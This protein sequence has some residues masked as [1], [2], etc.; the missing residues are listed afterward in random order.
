M[1]EKFTVIDL[2][3]SRSASVLTISGN[4]IKFNNQTAQELEYP[5]YIQF[6]VNAK[7]KQVAIRV[8]KENEPNSLQYCKDG[9]APKYAVK[10][11]LPVVTSIIRKMTNWQEKDSWNIPA[12]YFADEKALVY[13]LSAAYAPTKKGGWSARRESESAAAEAALNMS[14]EE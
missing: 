7:D 8:C 11:S 4:T 5:E 10:L 6:L 2:I 9:V 12:V 14:V 13:D 3:K 1:L